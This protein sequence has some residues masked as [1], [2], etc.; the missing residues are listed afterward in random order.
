[1][2][3]DDY[4]VVGPQITSAGSR[5]TIFKW[6]GYRMSTEGYRELSSNIIQHVDI[7][8]ELL[9]PAAARRRIPVLTVWINSVIESEDGRS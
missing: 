4:I 5:F 1:M 6:G 8:L 7:P 9:T 3:D 2:K